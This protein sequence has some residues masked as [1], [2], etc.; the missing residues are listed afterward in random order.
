MKVRRVRVAPIEPAKRLLSMAAAAVPPAHLISVKVIE[1]P[2]SMLRERTVIAMMWIEAVIHMAI[3]V[4]S[5]MEPG[6]G[7]GKDAPVEP[8]GPVIPVWSAGV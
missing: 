4:I 6:T 2:V 1:W 7:S 5:A 8:L 3:E